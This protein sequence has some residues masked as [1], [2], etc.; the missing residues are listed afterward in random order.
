MQVIFPKIDWIEMLKITDLMS[1]A[2]C[3]EKLRELRWGKGPVRCPRCES[4]ECK[5]KGASNKSSENRKYRCFVHDK[6][7]LIDY[8]MLDLSIIL[9]MN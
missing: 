8:P 3:Y 7:L 9:A 4:D 1:D 6:N 5:E 2:R